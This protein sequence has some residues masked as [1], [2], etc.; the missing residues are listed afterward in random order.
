[1]NEGG[2][3]RIS[4]ARDFDRWFRKITRCPFNYKKMTVPELKASLKKRNIKFKGLKGDMIVQLKAYDLD[5][6]ISQ[7]LLLWHVPVLIDGSPFP[8]MQ[9]P[10]EIRNII[11]KEVIGDG[12]VEHLLHKSYA[13]LYKLRNTAMIHQPTLFKICKSIRSEASPFFYAIRN[14]H[15]RLETYFTFRA[16]LTWLKT[17]APGLSGSIKTMHFTLRGRVSDTFDIPTI[18]SII[19][20]LPTRAPL[21]LHTLQN[22]QA[23][24]FEEFAEAL[25]KTVQAPCV[26]G[27]Y[28][29]WTY[30]DWEE[31]RGQ[32]SSTAL[33]LKVYGERNDI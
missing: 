29:K 7:Q 18:R 9:L 2:S 30:P 10:P 28:E 17:L 14:F 20:L 3:P 26:I 32:T 12:G 4:K 24:H 13:G 1:M 25:V 19:R 8:F 21:Y 31:C 11:Y 22:G 27:K 16:V 5:Q 15:F 6:Y 23:A 33:F